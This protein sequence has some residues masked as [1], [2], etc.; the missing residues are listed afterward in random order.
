MLVVTACTGQ[1]K[2]AMDPREQRRAS[3]S[4]PRNIKA[5]QTDKLDNACKH[6]QYKKETAFRFLD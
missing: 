2:V 4:Y 1:V 6:A 5:A 3:D